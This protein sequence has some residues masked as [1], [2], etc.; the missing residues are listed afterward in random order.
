V[1]LQAPRIGMAVELLDSCA[2]VSAAL[3]RLNLPLLVRPPQ[4]ASRS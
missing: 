3:E 2:A 1:V 4:R